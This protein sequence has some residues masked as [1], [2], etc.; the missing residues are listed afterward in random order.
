M[1]AAIRTEEEQ[2]NQSLGQLEAVRQGSF[3]GT[4]PFGYAREGK[5]WIPVEED[6][7]TLLALFVTFLRGVDCLDFKGRFSITDLGGLI[8]RN[9]A[10]V[11]RALQNHCY[12]GAFK[13]GEHVIPG[14]HPAII[15]QAIFNRVQDSLTRT[16][17]YATRGDRAKRQEIMHREHTDV[18]ELAKTWIDS[19]LMQEDT[20]PRQNPLEFFNLREGTIHGN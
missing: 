18:I 16:E 12:T 1:D 8:D 2:S 9:P 20:H 5:T 17:S 4:P 10:F 11:F 14:H 19:Y 13:W 15:P 7:V 6:A 3:S